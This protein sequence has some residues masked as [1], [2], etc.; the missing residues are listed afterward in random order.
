MRITKSFPYIFSAALLIIMILYPASAINN[1][2]NALAAWW[3]TVLPSLLPFIMLS[4]LLI[5]S[6]YVGRI[7]SYIA[8]AASHIFSLPGEGGLA[9]IL[10]WIC[11]YP[12]GAKII[13]QLM[14]NGSLNLTQAKCALA[15]ASCPGPMFMLGTVA[16]GF[17]AAPTL[18]PYIMASCYIGAV[19]CGVAARVALKPV[20]S[21]NFSATAIKN[22]GGD[23]AASSMQAML[24]VCGYMVMFSVIYGALEH[25]GFFKLIAGD[26]TEGLQGMVRPLSTGLLEVAAGCMQLGRASLPIYTKA[27]LAAAI[28]GGG[29][30]SVLLQQ[31]AMLGGR[32]SLAYMAGI[33]LLH[34]ISSGLVCVAAIA[35]FPPALPVSAA[36]YNASISTLS[37]SAAAFA[38]CTF[39]A[40]MMLFLPRR[41]S[42]SSR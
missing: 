7:A 39:I 32:I 26:T 29:G 31:K 23:I 35:I 2:K 5:N 19:I 21:R 11:G 37:F 24:T 33:K 28:A 22:N 13:A 1:A 40:A 34:F 6:G 10:G 12:G 41:K 17:L 8:P 36:P 42:R 3:E 14:D 4:G 27:V 38:V 15:A 30:L 25:I 20:A 18:G 9:I 16:A